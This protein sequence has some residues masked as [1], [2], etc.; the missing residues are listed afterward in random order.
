MALNAAKSQNYH[1]CALK[2][3][4]RIPIP[5]DHVQQTAISVI[6]ADM[7]GIMPSAADRQKRQHHNNNPSSNRPKQQHH[8]AV[9]NVQGE[10]PSDSDN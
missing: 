9:H 4:K 3:E 1:I 2:A 5:T 10:D 6:S 8:A 7:T